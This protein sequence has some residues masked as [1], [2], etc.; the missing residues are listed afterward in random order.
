MSKKRFAVVGGKPTPFALMTPDQ[1]ITAQRA[2]Y[3][4]MLTT[5]GSMICEPNSDTSFEIKI[6]DLG[7]FHAETFTM[8]FTTLSLVTGNIVDTGVCALSISIKDGANAL[9]LTNG[10]VPLDLIASPGRVRSNLATN[11]L[12]SAAPSSTLFNP[13]EL[14]YYFP[15]LSSIQMIVR[16]SSNTR[17]V[18]NIAFQG[19]RVRGIPS[20]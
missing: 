14:D 19:E 11:N 5:D 9:P 6:S 18:A 1:I 20:A 10:F 7:V 2:R 13:M 4:E 15:K 8:D 3:D 12:T 17:Q 16:N